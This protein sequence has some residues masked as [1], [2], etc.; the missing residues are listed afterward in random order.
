MADEDGRRSRIG[1]AFVKEVRAARPGQFDIRSAII[2]TMLS[3][4]AGL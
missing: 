2:D 4:L 1:Q 3:R